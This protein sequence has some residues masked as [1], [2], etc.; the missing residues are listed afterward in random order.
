MIQP[1]ENYVLLYNHPTSIHILFTTISLEAGFQKFCGNQSMLM[2][3]MTLMKLKEYKQKVF[4]F[5]CEHNL[6]CVRQLNT[7]PSFIKI[8]YS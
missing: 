7:A 5:I 8:N 1:K 4:N 2:M 6:L 3:P